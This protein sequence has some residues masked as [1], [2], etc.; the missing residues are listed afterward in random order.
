[1]AVGNKCLKKKQKKHKKSWTTPNNK[2]FKKQ[3][4]FEDYF[5]VINLISLSFLRTTVGV[6]WPNT[7]PTTRWNTTVIC[8]LARRKPHNWC[9][10][11]TELEKSVE[12]S[13]FLNICINCL[14]QKIG[15]KTP[16]KWSKLVQNVKKVVQKWFQI[17]L[18]R[19][20]V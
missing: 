20:K 5:C 17:C 19:T 18:K 13:H 6:R 1:M 7:C 4:I 3:I 12:M 8:A 16:Q 11:F 2:K 9:Y 15:Q 14:T 10:Q